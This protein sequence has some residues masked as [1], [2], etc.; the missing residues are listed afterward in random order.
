MT[1]RKGL[2]A[3]PQM[4]PRA[5][6]R[7]GAHVDSLAGP[8]ERARRTS[9]TRSRLGAALVAVGLGCCFW[10]SSASAQSS[11]VSF[12]VGQAKS[13]IGTT[14][15]VRTISEV[16]DARIYIKVRPSG[17]PPCAP[18]PDSDPGSYLDNRLDNFGGNLVR[19]GDTTTSRVHTFAGPGSFQFCGWLRAY[20][21]PPDRVV[22]IATTTGVFSVASP[23]GAITGVTPPS[24]APRGRPFLVTVTGQTE[25]RRRLI[26]AVRSSST[27]SCA[28]SPALDVSADD[29]T[30]DNGEELL[31]SFTRQVELTLETFGTYRLCS[32]IASDAGAREALGV[33]DTLI[34]VPAPVRATPV[35]PRIASIAQRGR[36]LVARLAVGAPGRL[37]VV[38]IGRGKRIGLGTVRIAAA[39]TVALTYR[40]PA[41]VRPGRYRL[42]VRFRVDNGPLA[43]ISRSITLR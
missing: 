14:V 19:P 34:T 22:S 1:T 27:P 33:N 7:V 40:R 25:V 6:F 39:R 32:W 12:D 15:S 21:L 11:I 4:S 18:D 42:E 28:A 16:N 5:V 8:S 9:W 13:E 31:G 41:R 43:R 30:S 17:G 23:V 20:Q 37:Q 38:L 3:M 26:T 2:L 29:A 36:R 24:P 10:A 35:K